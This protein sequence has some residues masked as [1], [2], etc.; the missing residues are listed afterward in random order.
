[1]KWVNFGGGHHI[2]RRD[3]N[4]EHLCKLINDFKNKFAVQIYLEPGEAIALESGI[5]VTEVLD[6]I[7][8]EMDI[9][10]IDG[11]ATTHLPDVLEMPY[12]PY[13][14]GSGLPNEKKF[15]YKI[16][17]NSCLAGDIIGDYSFEKRL[18]VGDKLIFTDMAHYTMVK[19]NTFNG[20]KLPDI[21]LYD[22]KQLKCIKKFGYKDFKNRLS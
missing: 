2:T 6:I 3:Y 11:S 18:K 10:I 8:N 16:A 4:I 21:Y 14:L 22:N 19:T 20:V 7:K 5:Y 12:R 13:I 17:G 9:V 15:T 1:M